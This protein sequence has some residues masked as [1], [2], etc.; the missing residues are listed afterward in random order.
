MKSNKYINYDLFKIIVVSLFLFSLFIFHAMAASPFIIFTFDDGFKNV[1]DLA[2][3]ILSSEGIPATVYITT[4]FV[5]TSNHMTYDDLRTLQNIYGWEVASHTVTHPDMSTLSVSNL[6]WE[7]NTSKTSLQ[8]QNL[9]IY[10]FATP[11]GISNNT[12]R[13]YVAKYYFSER[14]I[15]PGENQAPYSN[16]QRSDYYLSSTPISTIYGY[17]DGAIAN[18]TC[19]ILTFHDIVEGTAT[20]DQVNTTTLQQIVNYVT[21]KKIKPIRTRDI[22][23]NGTYIDSN[24]LLN[25]SMETGTTF[26]ANWMSFDYADEFYDK[27][28]SGSM[29]YP[30][31]S[32]WVRGSADRSVALQ[33]NESAIND[34]YQ[35]YYKVFMN[36]QD[37]SSGTTRVFIEDYNSG[38][39]WIGETLSTAYTSNYVGN[40]IGTYT[41]TTG[42]SIFEF[43]LYTYAGSVMNPK[44]DNAELGRISANP[45]SWF[46]ANKTEITEG[47]SISFT[48]LSTG[49]PTSWNWSFGDGN[50][51]TS[52][53]TTHIYELPGTYSINLT[54]T[55]YRGT[56]NLT[57]TNYI[58]V[59]EEI[60]PP[61]TDFIANVTNGTSPMD[62][63]FSDLSTNEPDT[64]YWEFGDGNTSS[65]QHPSHTYYVGNFTVALYSSNVGGGDW[66]NKTN[67]ITVWDI[68]PTP[69]PEPTPYASF[70]SD[71]NY[72]LPPLC[73]QFNDTS[74]LNGES[75]TAWYWDFGDGFTDNST[76]N[77]YHC[78]NT[79]DIFTI[80]FTT[81]INSTNYTAYGTISTLEHGIPYDLGDVKVLPT[82][83]FIPDYAFIIAFV[84]GIISL[85]YSI[86]YKN[87][88]TSLLSFGTFMILSFM[89][90]FLSKFYDFTIYEQYNPS[91]WLYIPVVVNT[92]PIYLTW[93]CYSL[94]ML[95]FVL[96]LITMYSFA[97]NLLKPER[98]DEDNL[99]DF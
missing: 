46:D 56:G 82:V 41:P 13:S 33:Y 71:T 1:T 58:I 3:P 49:S 47:E 79:S 43:Y 35:Y 99:L 53:N 65:D 29:P 81:T 48:D 8:S 77:P 80:T 17:I 69:T 28:T 50:F 96:L 72:G 5:G 20:S 12:I 87:A 89:T 19:V 6:T 27:N 11:Y 64:W 4:N 26:P 67:Y 66:E 88:F 73:I 75:Q 34:S 42:T 9:T 63:Q 61:I 22:T 16:Y 78:F 62:I 57:K 60:L 97:M 98:S 59:N 15:S 51:S 23:P 24:L 55:N 36:L 25:P 45:Y 10:N 76:Q 18:N 30:T 91:N 93:L 37:Y 21:S 83:G 84:I 74:F 85:M 52:Q 54:V 94:S 2:R 31:R 86:I 44:F 14:S 95:S 39:G 38:W 68:A 7:L 70:T 92:V 40:I 32:I 90:P